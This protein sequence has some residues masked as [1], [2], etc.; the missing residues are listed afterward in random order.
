MS[1][2][3]F[4]CLPYNTDNNLTIGHVVLPANQISVNC[5]YIES[6]L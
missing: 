2:K 4:A 1:G 3:I 5:R 6:I